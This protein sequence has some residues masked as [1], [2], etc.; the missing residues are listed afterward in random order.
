MP[1]R[2]IRRDGSDYG[3]ALAALLPQGDAWPRWDD[4]TLIRTTDALGEIFGYVDSR[5]A[6][7]LEVETDPRLTLEMLEDWERNFRLPDPCFK[8]ALTIDE[9]HKILV[10]K[11]TL[12]GAQSREFFIGMAA[13]LGYTITI[14]ERAPF[15]CGISQVGDTSQMIN[16]NGTPGDDPQAL[17]YRWRIGP[18]EMRFLWTVHVTGA[19]LMWFR[20]GAGEAGVQYHLTIGFAEDLECLLNRWKPAHTHIVFDYSN[21]GHGSDDPYAGLP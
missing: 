11:M 20:A 9:R 21:L 18:P 2:H 4:S 13:W 10:F 17:D 19:P 7:L 15:T 1:D 8:S 3:R 12:L 5:A 6:D 16:W 14:T